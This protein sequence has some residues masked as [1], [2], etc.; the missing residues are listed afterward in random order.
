MR[1]RG[2]STRRPSLALFREKLAKELSLVERGLALP[3]PPLSLGEAG[4]EERGLPLT[5]VAL[6]LREDCCL[7]C[8]GVG[9]VTLR[10]CCGIFLATLRRFKNKYTRAA[11]TTAAVQAPQ[12]SPPPPMSV[13]PIFSAA[14][15]AP[16]PTRTPGTFSAAGEAALDWVGLPV[17]VAEAV[18]ER[19]ASEVG[20]PLVPALELLGDAGRVGVL[21][22]EAPLDSEGVGVG[23]LVEVGVFVGAG[24]SEGVVVEEK[25]AEGVIEGDAPELSEAVGEHD[26]VEE[27]VR[28][29]VEVRVGV[30]VGVGVSE[31]VAVPEGVALAVVLL[32]SELLGVLEAEAPGLRLL[33]GEDDTVEL[34]ESVVLGVMDAVPVPLEVEEPEDVPEGVRVAVA[35]LERD[36]LGVL[37]A[38]APVLKEAVGLAVRVELAEI[39]LDGVMEPVPVPLRVGVGVG[40]P[41]GVGGGVPLLERLVLSVLLAEAPGLS[42]AVGEAVTV[43]LAESVVE[44]VGAAVPV[45]VPVGVAVAV[46]LGVGGGVPLLD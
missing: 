25:E 8:N 9:C 41:V 14:A 45:P 34:A 10:G 20:G 43:L 46:G 44:G 30:A 37:L 13:G 6:G 4:V 1:S 16:P 42:V 15:M 12:N 19:V 23:V 18:G 39:V 7:C 35:L 22:A 29:E 28:V 38:E 40:V 33:V 3:S 27:V 32:E 2:F 36:T 21:E 17:A 5:R 24:V 26:T 31:G 11:I